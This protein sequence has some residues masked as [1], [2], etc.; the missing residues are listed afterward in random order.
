MYVA[1]ALTTES[2][3]YL[4]I[5]YSKAA[6]MADK[7]NNSGSRD[8]EPLHGEFGPMGGV[9]MKVKSGYILAVFSGTTGEQDLDFEERYLA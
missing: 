1:G 8:R 7:K 3:N 2:A 5:A 4:A 9:I 6:E